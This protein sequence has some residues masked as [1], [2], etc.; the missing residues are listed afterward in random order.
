MLSSNPGLTGHQCCLCVCISCFILKNLPLFPPILYEECNFAD[1]SVN[2]LPDWRKG[3]LKVSFTSFHWDVMLHSPWW[4][5]RIQ[6]FLWPPSD[7]KG[8]AASRRGQGWRT[9][10]KITI[11]KIKK[12]KYLAIIED[13]RFI[14][15][16]HSAGWTVAPEK[17][18][19]NY[20]H[21][22]LGRS[23]HSLHLPPPALPCTNTITLKTNV[24]TAL[25]PEQEEQEIKGFSLL[26]TAIVCCLYMQRFCVLEPFCI[27]VSFGFGSA[28]TK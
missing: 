12:N 13:E 22:T 20:R 28:E 6:T 3:N 7:M 5:T 8:A 26:S 19:C 2:D 14:L 17:S 1:D 4:R 27:F 15:H 23:S 11:N 24:R 10:I 9:W 21:P 25:G 18:I 16:I